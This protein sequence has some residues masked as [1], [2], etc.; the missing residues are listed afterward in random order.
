MTPFI[1]MMEDIGEL[2]EAATPVVQQRIELLFTAAS[3][4]NGMLL[5]PVVSSKGEYY[6]A[7]FEPELGKLRI[8]AKMEFDSPE[9]IVFCGDKATL[10]EGKT[11]ANTH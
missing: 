2:M 4:L 5:V 7:V 11:D 3:G 6:L 9:D 1:K 8:V 10:I